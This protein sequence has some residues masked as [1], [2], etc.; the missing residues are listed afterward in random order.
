[1]AENI[2]RTLDEKLDKK[3]EKLPA[4]KPKEG[5]RMKGVFLNAAK[6]KGDEWEHLIFLTVEELGTKT[7]YSVL[8]DRVLESQFKELG[9]KPGDIIALEFL[10]WKE[11]KKGKIDR[12]TGELMKYK[13]WK[14]VKA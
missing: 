13:N 12:K 14:V 5:D 7:Q 1:M 8:Q 9:I 11:N 2:E 10:G 3:N 4:W 6:G